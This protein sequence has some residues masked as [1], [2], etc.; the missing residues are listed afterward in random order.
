M[1]RYLTSIFFE[2]AGDRSTWRYPTGVKRHFTAADGRRPQLFKLAVDCR[3]LT[4]CSRLRPKR[5]SPL[6]HRHES[7]V[8]YDALSNREN[9]SNVKL[10]E[11]RKYALSL[12]ETNEQPHFKYSSFRVKGKIFS[13][14]PEDKNH[15]NIFVDDERLEL[16]ISMFPDAYEKLWWGKKVVGVTV[17]LSVADSSDVQD[18]LYA[19]WKR[20]APKRVV[21]AYSK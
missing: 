4:Q 17:R 20:K 19:A 1:G 5:C 12:P 3:L 14:V 15:L 8:L 6:I 10:A 13:T 16:A 7:Q 18:L 2:L 9:G 11:A 21:E